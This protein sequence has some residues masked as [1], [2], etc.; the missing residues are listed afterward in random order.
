MAG[1][2]L[3]SIFKN[4]GK[5]NANGNSKKYRAKASAESTPVN[6]TNLVFEETNPHSP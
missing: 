3:K 4:G 6:T 2:S 1:T 5:I